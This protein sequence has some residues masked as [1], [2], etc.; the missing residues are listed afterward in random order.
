MSKANIRL[1]TFQNAAAVIG[2]GVKHRVEEKA[3]MVIELSGT[4]V[5]T[6]T[7]EATLDAD[8][9]TPIYTAV[10]AVNIADGTKSTTATAVGLYYVPA[11]GADAIRARIS[12]YTSGNVTAKGR[13]TE[14][15]MTFQDV[16]LETAD[17]EIGAVEL[18]NATTDDRAVVDASGN[19]Q[20]KL[21]V[22]IPAGVN[23]IGA[24]DLDSDATTGAAIPAVGQAVS[25]TD[26]TNARVL[27]T[28]TAGE[29]QVDVL[30]MPTVTVDSE[31]PVAAALGDAAANPTAPAVGADL[32]GFNGATW[33][34]MRNNIEAVA[35]ASAARTA[36]TA[37]ADFVNY[38]AKGVR[39]RINVTAVGAAPSITVAIQ[40]KDSISG[41]YID[42][43]VSVAIT[44]TG[45][46]A[47]LTLYP[48]VTA[49]P[50][51]AVS[52]PLP[53]TF[54]INVTHANADSI[55]Y[56]VDHALIT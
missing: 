15:P 14:A 18:K 42:R 28:D 38:N 7:F 36:T 19:I 50:N 24:V 39:V 4:F 52:E 35:L 11:H 32:Q 3:G 20:V 40:E 34:R 27:K 37:S 10:A 17:I 43:L 49:S 55:T 2:N 48:G 47:S 29:L 5:A 41:N 1:V 45:Q 8:A 6:V 44:T 25:G 33:D 22:A 46:K 51:V 16:Q 53:R 9:G 26:G 23:K 12:A 54:R 21:G 13:A 31:L 56:S 30:T